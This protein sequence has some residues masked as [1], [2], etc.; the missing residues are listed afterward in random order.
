MTWK[1]LIKSKTFMFALLVTL[2]AFGYFFARELGRQYA[3]QGEIATL[4]QEIGKIEDKNQELND[5]I[6]YFKTTSFQEKEV[7]SKLKPQKPGRDLVAPPG[8]TGLFC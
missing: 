2:G 1:K 7:P 4:E 6:A 8:W 5:L 3:I